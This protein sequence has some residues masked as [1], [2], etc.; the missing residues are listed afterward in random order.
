[1][2][3]TDSAGVC[4]EAAVCSAAEVELRIGS[5]AAT[6]ATTVAAVTTDPPV[7]SLPFDAAGDTAADDDDDGAWPEAKS[8]FDDESNP[9]WIGDPGVNAAAP[10]ALPVFGAADDPRPAKCEEAALKGEPRWIAAGPAPALTGWCTG[11]L[12]GDGG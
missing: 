10:I 11:P 2:D 9:S 3:A 5:N 4:A 6:E 12:P 1:M 8:K 7:P